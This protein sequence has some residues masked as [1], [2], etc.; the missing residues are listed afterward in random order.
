MN[1]DATSP[2][3]VLGRQVPSPMDA[4]STPSEIPRP[5]VKARRVGRGRGRDSESQATAGGQAFGESSSILQKEIL[6]TDISHS[7]GGTTCPSK[8]E[9]PTRTGG[10]RPFDPAPHI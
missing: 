6:K 9:L 5:R 10:F 2:E 3:A 7:N 1:P 8:K 4:A